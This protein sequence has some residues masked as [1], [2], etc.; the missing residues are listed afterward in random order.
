MRTEQQAAERNAQEL[1]ATEAQS[2]SHPEG[3]QKK[4][5]KKKKVVAYTR[6]LARAHKDTDAAPQHQAVVLRLVSMV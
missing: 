6:L 2:K 5:K 4:G 1:L 3:G